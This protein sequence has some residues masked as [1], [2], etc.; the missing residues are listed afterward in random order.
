MRTTSTG[1]PNDLG[2]SLQAM[3]SLAE[4]EGLRGKVQCIYLDP[5]YG[6]TSFNGSPLALKSK[7]AA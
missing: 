5:P 2:D 7:K 3:A 1:P 4:C 6:I